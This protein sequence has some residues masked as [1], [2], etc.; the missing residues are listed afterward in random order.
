MYFHG[1]IGYA[2]I[3][4]ASYIVLGTLWGIEGISN[5]D[6]RVQMMSGTLLGLAVW[7]RIEGTLFSLAV[8]AA[9]GGTWI[10]SRKGRPILRH[11]LLPIIG[12]GAIWTGFFVAFGA[13]GSQPS[14]AT[15][16]AFS[17]ILDGDLNLD[18][19][20][21][22]IR[23]FIGRTIELQPWGLLFPASALL[24]LLNFK[25]LS[26]RRQPDSFSLLLTAGL[27][28]VMSLGFYYVGSFGAV[29]GLY[30]WLTR[31]F[32]RAFFQSAFLLGTLAVLLVSH[33]LAEPPKHV[34][35]VKGIDINTDIDLASR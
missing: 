32:P 15:G 29:P 25:K 34:S 26:P 2:N 6:S 13:A 24:I 28:G 4:M 7:S 9:L 12:F 8:V 22:I 1:T 5:S 14:Q 19:V 3:P 35:G 31:S 21:I 33:A 20:R 11:W 17:S 27:M 23:Y 18:A 10:I 16:S 30:D